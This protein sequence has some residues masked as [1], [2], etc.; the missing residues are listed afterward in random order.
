MRGHHAAVVHP[1][2]LS[3]RFYDP[4]TSEIGK[5]PGDLRLWSAEDFHEVAD[6]NLLVSNEVQ[7]PQASVVTQCLEEAF[8]V[9]GSLSCHIVIYTP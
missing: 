9:V 8:E 5:M 4:G 6:A 3:P 2:S 1:H 7:E